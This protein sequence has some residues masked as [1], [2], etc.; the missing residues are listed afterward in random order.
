MFS[1]RM[2]AAATP[3]DQPQTVD[4]SLA[5]ARARLDSW[6]DGASRLLPNIVVALV[7]LAIFYGL[8][9][10][11]QRL[12]VGQATRRNRSNLGSVL[13]GFVKAM[14]LLLGFLLAATI[15]IPSLKPGDLIAVSGS[16]RSRSVL[17]SRTSCRTGSPGCSFSS[18]NHSRFTTRSRSTATKARSNASR[19]GLPLSR[20]TMASGS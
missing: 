16:A 11:A 9:L 8:A 6:V 7:L 5:G 4:F 13:G 17:P 3:Q 19:P 18:G 2:L 12:I 20:P 10:L 14:I 15:V 1:L